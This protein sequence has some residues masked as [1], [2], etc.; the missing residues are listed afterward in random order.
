MINAKLNAK[1]DIENGCVMLK[2]ESEDLIT[3]SFKLVRSKYGENK[4]Q[5]L[6]NFIL[7]D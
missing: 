2:L 6:F 4:W 3:G 1:L 5:E 7:E